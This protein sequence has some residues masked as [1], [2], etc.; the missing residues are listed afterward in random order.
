MTKYVM[1]KTNKPLTRY[2]CR[3]HAEY[4][5]RRPLTANCD[6]EIY[7]SN[8]TW[9]RPNFFISFDYLSDIPM[10]MLDFAYWKNKDNDIIVRIQKLH[11]KDV[12]KALT[13]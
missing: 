8:E 6:R 13:T 3:K 2:I 1:M 4:S 9:V 11:Q 7:V 5:N 12:K 10:E